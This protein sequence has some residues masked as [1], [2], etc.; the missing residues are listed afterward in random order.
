[1]AQ[2]G[3]H[4]VFA[5]AARKTFS[6]NKWFATGLA[7]GAL[8]PDADSYIVAYGFLLGGMDTSQAQELF[9]RTFTH[10]VFFAMG[11]GL[12]FY[13]LSRLRRDKNLAT[14]GFGLATGIAVLHIVPDIFIWFRGVEAF[15]PLGGINL[16]G[17]VSYPENIQR[18][19]RATNFWSFSLYF[20][21]LASV[22]RKSNTN[23]DYMPKLRRYTQVQLGI[24][25]LFTLLAFILSSKMYNILDGGA[26]LLF[27]FPNAMWVTWQMRETI[28]EG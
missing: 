10:S 6:T 25:V 9:H 2:I 7:L 23:Q 26:L 4:P 17:T 1:M 24:S 8:L 21:Y 15:W 27:A 5:L 14:F 16:W 19:E 20:I 11:I 22:A 18:L 12:L 3:L 28:E 13:L